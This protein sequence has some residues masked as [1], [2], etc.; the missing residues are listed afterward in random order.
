MRENIE[1]ILFDMGGTLRSNTKHLGDVDLKKI[2]EMISLLGVDFDDVAFIQLLKKR[3]K[4]YKNWA[5]K[6]LL[7]LDEVELWSRWML[8]ESPSD[9]VSRLALQLSQLWRDA[10][11]RHEVFPETQEMVRTLF[12]R[13]YRLGL[14]S[15]TTSSVEVPASPGRIGYRRLL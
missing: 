2:H 6:T 11:I 12:R 15:N 13:G 9:L 3:G 14:V 5:E 8:P 4:A 1:A 10:N 7:E